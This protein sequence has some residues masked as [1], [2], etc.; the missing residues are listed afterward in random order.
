MPMLWE[1]TIHGLQQDVNISG[2]LISM[3]T[4]MNRRTFVK[5]ALLSAGYVPLSGGCMET[6]RQDASP[7][8]RPNVI[9][10]LADDLGRAQLGCYQDTYTRS[11]LPQEGIEYASRRYDI[12]KALAAAQKCTPNIDRLAAEG[13]R[14]LDFQMA[15]SCAPSRSALMTARYPQRYGIYRNGDVYH[16]GLP[17]DEYLL[18]RLMQADGYQTA[19]I[20]K[21]HLGRKRVIENCE[22]KF[23]FVPEMHPLKQGFDYYFGFDSAQTT[24]YNS[25]DLWRNEIYGVEPKGYLTDQF[26]S[27]AIGFIDRCREKPFFLYLSYNAPHVPIETPPQEYLVSFESTGNRKADDVFGSIFAMDKGIGD[28]LSHLAQTGIE[29]DTLVIF[30]SDNGAWLG[31]PLPTNGSLRGYKR[32]YTA[33]D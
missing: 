2:N 27:E 24:Y 22:H 18:P 6:P 12:D 16:Q 20:G 26:T 31:S 29:K 7:R 14:F 23:S 3:V 15:P 11:S 5:A 21:W 25:T 28:I 8:K 32:N 4:W 30:A 1:N 33:S 13:T 9:L 19:L 17:A 10:I